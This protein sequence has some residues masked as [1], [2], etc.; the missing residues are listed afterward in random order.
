MNESN[1][2]SPLSSRARDL[3]Q[4]MRTRPLL[5]FFLL[6][7]A[8]SWAAST[9]AV[10]SA[11]GLLS[12]DYTIAYMAKQW[13]GPAL[14]AYIMVAVLAG[15]PGLRSLRSGIR[16]WRVDWRWYVFLVLGTT[17]LIFLGI[18]VQP[19]ALARFHGLPPHFVTTYIMTFAAVFLG[20]G[21]PEEIGWRGF[22]LPRLQRRYGPLSGSLI[23]GAAWALWHALFY[24]TPYHGGG[25]GTD[26]GTLLAN[27]LLFS[28]MVLALAINF[29]WVFNRTRENVLMASLFHA[30][31][32]TPQ[33][34]WAGAFLEVGASNS[35]AGEAG[36]ILAILIPFGVLAVG[37]VLFT[38]GRLG[39]SSEDESR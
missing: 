4:A 6:A 11:W 28:V 15:K 26:F 21:L 30:A 12:G 9:P 24:L 20:V 8:F 2:L 29:T 36:Y 22:A 25:P 23:L 35:P 1:A 19:G 38:R 3:R 10:L 14:A 5:W 7:Y 34:V 27:F 18:V 31:I 13:F 17:A 32:D 16:R 37:I 39:L 33:L